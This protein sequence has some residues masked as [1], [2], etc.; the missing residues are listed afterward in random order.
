MR[1][2]I[3]LLATFLVLIVLFAMASVLYERF[4]SARVIANLFA[5]KYAYLGIAAIGMTF[6]I[7]S[8]GID[9]SVGAVLAFTVTLVA[10]LIADYSWHPL[11]AIALALLVGT[12]FGA[13]MG[14]LIQ[15]YE[16]PPFLVTL[17]GMFFARGLAFVVSAESIT[18]DHEFYTAVQEV[19][20]TVGPKAK[21]KIGSVI[22]LAVLGV[23]V[24]VAHG[25]PFGRNIYAMGGNE[26]SARLMGL[27][28]ARTKIMVY[29]LNGFCA[30]LAGVV[31]T[32]FMPSGNPAAAV[33][34]ELDVIAA[35]VIGG[36]LLTGGVGYVAGTLGGVLIF[37]TIETALD[38]DGRLS[39][40]W[41]RITISVLLLMFILLQRQL[42]RF[43][44]KT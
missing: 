17:A 27:P 6:V 15:R 37:G 41:L 20:F 11:T 19:K 5:N 13:G 21:L 39:S 29:A 42:S 24:F 34:L 40:S 33:G 1:R 23:A 43:T 12:C 36:T 4:F 10:S 28:V 7:I 22:F 32:L 16:L 35:V 31:A 26:S 30:A 38:F 8:G 3:P 25:T 44:R 18:I 2:F 14:V 9:L